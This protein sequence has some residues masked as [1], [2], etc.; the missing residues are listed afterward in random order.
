MTQGRKEQ[1]AGKSRGGE[2]P[3]MLPGFMPGLDRLSRPICW[4]AITHPACRATAERALGVILPPKGGIGSTSEPAS[5][6]PRPLLTCD[7]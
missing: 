4:D 7:P 2:D 1:A 6:A 5:P 3:P